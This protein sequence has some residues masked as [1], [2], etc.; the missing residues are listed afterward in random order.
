[1]VTPIDEFAT[2]D[3]IDHFRNQLRLD[4]RWSAVAA[5]ILVVLGVV[6]TSGWTLALAGLVAAMAVVRRRAY[7]FIDRGELTG[8]VLWAAAGTWGV[9]IGVVAIVPEALPIVVIN[10]IHPLVI[11]ALTLSA[12]RMRWMMAAGVVVAL[13]IGALGFRSGGVD[14]TEQAPA[15]F[16]SFVM[17]A[18]LAGHVVV[19]GTWVAQANRVRLDG[20]DR[21]RA[22]HGELGRSRARVVS[23]AD[24]ER[25][26]IERDIHD[27]AQQRLV[28]LAVRLRLAGQL[29]DQGRAMTGDELRELDDEVRRALDELRELARGVYPAVLTERGVV[30]AIRHLAR[31]TPNPVEVIGSLDHDLD[32]GSASTLYFITAEALQNASKHAGADAPV[33]VELASDGPM[34]R[35]VVADEGT[36]FD[37][38]ATPR[39]R[40]LL[41]MADRAGAAG[42]ELTITSEPGGGTRVDVAIPVTAVPR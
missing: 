18:Y 22:A 40:G 37:V 27:G 41:N 42:G 36:G 10:L 24:R 13:V 39:S 34:V 14:L 11:G 6:F 26:R 35:L 16:V 8:A 29:V 4:Q 21:L 15:W 5:V 17:T 23:A 30:E 9:A 1:M 12:A 19:I 7:T 32:P 3:S 20:V 25:Q 2:R 33:R 31:T 28:A 38:D